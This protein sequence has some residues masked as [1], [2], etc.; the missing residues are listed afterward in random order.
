MKKSSAPK[1]PK[2]KYYSTDSY[3]N[4][5]LWVDFWYQLSYIKQTR[6]RSILEVGKGSGTLETMLEMRGFEYTSLDIDNELLPDVVGNVL[7]MPF[8]DN[9]FDTVCAFQVLEHLPFNKFNL[10]LKEMHR[11][12]KKYVVISLPYACFYVSLGF[13]LFYARFLTSVFKLFHLKP[14]EPSYI[15]LSIPF[16][17]LNKLGL[18]KSHYWEIGRKNTSLQFIKK[19]FKKSELNLVGEYDRIFY[20]Y[21]RYFILKKS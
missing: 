21:H 20:P 1:Q 11:V 10:C 6:P 15:N 2:A 13:Q 9:S 17:F 16:F 18:P 8:K 19:Q 4:F 14:F 3:E 5:N 7:D 12:S